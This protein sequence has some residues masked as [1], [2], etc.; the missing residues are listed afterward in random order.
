MK[1]RNDAF[2]YAIRGSPV[3][4]VLVPETYTAYPISPA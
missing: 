4:G 2:R 3:V 1:M